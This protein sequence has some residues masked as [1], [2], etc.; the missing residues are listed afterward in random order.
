[1][2]S[3]KKHWREWGLFDNG[4]IPVGHMHSNLLEIALERGVPALLVWLLLLRHLCPHVVASVLETKQ[5]R[6]R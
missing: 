4:K 6:S 2:D 3:I 5:K 1:M